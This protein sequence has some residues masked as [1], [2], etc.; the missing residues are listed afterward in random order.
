MGFLQILGLLLVIVM[1]KGCGAYDSNQSAK[2]IPGVT[3]PFYKTTT[4]ELPVSTDLKNPKD[5]L[6]QVIYAAH[7]RLLR[8]LMNG[9][10]KG[11]ESNELSYPYGTK[12]IRSRARVEGY[13]ETEGS[14][15]NPDFRKNFIQNIDRRR[16]HRYTLTLRWKWKSDQQRG[17]VKLLSLTPYFRPSVSSV[18]LGEQPLASVSYESFINELK[19]NLKQT[20]QD[21]LKHY[22]FNRL[23]QSK[24]ND[25]P[26][27]YNA[28]TLNRSENVVKRPLI[29]RSDST[30]KGTLGRQFRAYHQKIL[31]ASRN[32]DIQAYKNDSLRKTY[33]SP[34]AVKRIGADKKV[35][36]VAKGT[37]DQQFF[38]DTTIYDQLSPSQFKRYWLIERWKKIATGLF[39]IKPIALSPVYRPVRGGVTLG[40]VSLFW[41]KMKDLSKVLKPADTRW[42]KA[43]SY[44]KVQRQLADQSYSLP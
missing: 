41:V 8:K 25:E 29:F 30:F 21:K 31:K 40:G 4:V 3:I 1:M 32:G 33:Q 28:Q 39:E 15:T 34:K 14:F 23:Q 17:S 38:S 24:V 44:L 2:R 12:K 35:I 20:L 7:L 6:S 37:G 43:Y 5:S 19:P 16:F 26:L 10:L 27:A 9:K 22:L 36:K 11:Y 13:E 42:L 18:S